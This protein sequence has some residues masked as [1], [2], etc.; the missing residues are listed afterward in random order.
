MHWQLSERQLNLGQPLYLAIINLTPDSFSDG[1]ALPSPK[2]AIAYGEG[3]LRQGAHVLDVGAESTRPGAKPVGHEEQWARMAPVL[4]GLK[5][6]N[7]GCILSIDTRSPYVARL[8]LESGANIVN[9]VTGF[10][11]P[12]MLE[13]AKKSNCGLIAMRSRTDGDHI[14]MPEYLDPTP[15]TTDA[16]MRELGKIK[17]RLLAAGIEPERILLDPGFGFGTTFLEDQSLWG[18]LSKMPSILNWPVER[19]CIGISR[20]RFV[21]H[22]FGVQGNEYLDK[23]TNDLHSQAAEMGYKVF[24][25]HS[26]PGH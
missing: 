6:D 26:L 20:K 10:Q 23:K 15:K 8:S 16:A 18:A 9:D 14:L 7:Q 1:G 19:F 4:D 3:L 13:L 25:T 22:K 12:D 11:N 5:K 17:D 21:A 2:D 24:R